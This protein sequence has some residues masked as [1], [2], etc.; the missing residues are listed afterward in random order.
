MPRRRAR[1]KPGR[2]D[3]AADA[4]AGSR[5]TAQYGAHLLDL[6]LG[7]SYTEDSFRFPLSG[8][9]RDTEGGDLTSGLRYAYAPDATQPLPLFEASALYVT[10]SAERDYFINDR[11]EKGAKFGESELDASTLSLH[12]GLN[13]P[14]GQGFVLSPGLSWSY[15]TRDNTDTYDGATRPTFT[16]TPGGL[17]ER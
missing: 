8:G 3:Y 13:V 11:G 12:A 5:T 10:G 14:L 17:D 1:H 16:F 4:R 7:Y 9:V 2:R 6:G 15:A